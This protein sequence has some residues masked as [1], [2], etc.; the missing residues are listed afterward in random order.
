MRSDFDGGHGPIPVNSILQ[1]LTADV[2][3]HEVGQPGGFGDTVDCDNVVVNDRGR[4][5][6]FAFK[7]ISRRSPRG[8][9]RRQDFDGRKAIE[10]TVEPLQDDSHAPLPDHA[11]DFVAGESAEHLGIIGWIQKRQ[12]GGRIVRQSVESQELSRFSPPGIVGGHVGQVLLARLAV[13][14]VVS[15]AIR[16]R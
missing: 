1:G 3:H 7:S 15:Q 11:R 8:E 5:L 2:G 10:R 13:I 4:R 12:G 6:G 14:Q 9:L 16:L